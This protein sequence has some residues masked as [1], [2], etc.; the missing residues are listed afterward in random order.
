MSTPS[1]DEFVSAAMSSFVL[2]VP[3]AP[4]V[5]AVLTEVSDRRVMGD[6]E[7]FSIVF[8]GPSDSLF[9]QGVVEMTHGSIGSFELFLVP[10]G[11]TAESITYEAV[12]NRLVEQAV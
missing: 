6:T 4:P 11:R 5:E 10:I 9:E 1:F 3:G 7:N 12:F 8:T 2:T